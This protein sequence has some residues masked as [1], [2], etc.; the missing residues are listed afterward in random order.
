M[1]SVLAARPITPLQSDVYMQQEAVIEGLPPNLRVVPND[2]HEWRRWR[3]AINAYRT[4]RRRACSRDVNE[5]KREWIRCKNDTAYFL[6][7]WGVIFEPRTVESEPPSWKPFILFPFQV[8]M[9]RWIEHILSLNPESSNGRGD[10]VIEKSRDMG[11]TNIFC[12]VA[13][14]HFIWDDVFVAGFI[15]KKFE[16][17]DKR[18]SMGTIFYRL[19]ALLGAEDAVPPNLRLPKFLQPAGFDYNAHITWGAAS[20]INPEPG[21][22]CILEGETTTKLSGVSNRSTMRLND[23]AARFDNFSGTWANQQ[24]TSDHRFAL[25]TADISHG[26]AFK[27]MADL[28]RECLVSPFKAGPSLLRLEYQLHPFHT[29][30]WYEGQWARAQ[31]NMDP[32]EFLRE[33]NIDYEAERGEEVYPRFKDAKA[34]HAPYDPHGGQMYCFIDP[35][36]RDPGAI[37]WVQRDV[38]K[39][40]F[41]VV[42]SFQGLGGEGADFYA[43]VLTGI[44]WSGDR[45]Y[46]YTEYPRIDEIM[47]FTRNIT[48]PI[49]YAGDPAGK[50]KGAGGTERDTWYFNLT[51]FAR[52]LAGASVH[53]NTITADNARTY[54]ARKQAIN[55]IAPALRFHEGQGGAWVLTCLKNSRYKKPSLRGHEAYEPLKPAHDKHSHMRTA[56]E[57]GA[58]WLRF[59]SMGAQNRRMNAQKKGK[60]IRRSLSGNVVSGGQRNLYER[61][62]RT[63]R[64]DGTPW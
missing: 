64:R 21:K 53:V 9:V 7:I 30:E 36:I 28:G 55:W 10:G 56:L 33:Y 14:K 43:S 15:S 18:G 20:I 24:A 38:N 25:S 58:T 50:A 8:H 62:V 31:S 41:N 46:D 39:G 60:P 48:Q 5:Q 29:K 57:Y 22:S 32:G 4:A 17:V 27:N 35:G 19:R 51:M 23:E 44:Y 1:D 2:Q 12:G 47:E 45:Q 49:T 59:E 42:E 26:P 11:A 3:D 63:G 61:N 54:E 34:E 37:V 52:E 16:D 13:V 6:C 40:G